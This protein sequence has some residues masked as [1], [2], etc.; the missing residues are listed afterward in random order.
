MQE[1]FKRRIIWNND[2]KQHQLVEYGT[3]KYSYTEE[4]K[5]SIVSE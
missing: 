5:I 4:E 1:K 2:L 3:G